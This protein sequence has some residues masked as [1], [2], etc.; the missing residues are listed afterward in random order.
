MARTV[1]ILL[2]PVSGKGATGRRGPELLQSFA[3]RG[4]E[5]R[6]LM[7]ESADH[8]L[9]L[10]RRAVA[11]GIDAL[12]AAGGDGTINTALQ[13]VACTDTPLG[14]VPLG[15]GND[16]ARLL[17][18]PR[19]DPDEAVDVVCR[20]R[21]RAVD[22]A[23]V[24]TADGAMRYFLGVLSAGFDSLV[25][26]RA[27]Q[28][29]WP[30]GDARYILAML[31]ELRTFAPCDFTITIDG[32]VLQDRGMLAAVGN[33]VSYGGGM[34]VC[35]GAV[36]DD[37]LLQVTWLHESSK[38]HFVTT[39]PKVFK[40]THIA[41]PGV[42]QHSGRRIRIEAPGQLAYADGDR[43]GELP[44]DIEVHPGGLRVLTPDGQ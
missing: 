21:P 1:A 40:G 14:I 42:T 31:A 39:F 17:G 7:G 38:L 37:G 2:N 33:G 16:N 36:I 10:A 44:I 32:Q 4:V 15:T 12:V 3:R 13:A 20:F 23:S 27:N 25:T 28:M 26:E 18:L 35:E 8:A 41:D 22:V 19:K 43:M 5:A 34:R 6:L 11:D 9:E 29:T 30:K 24:T